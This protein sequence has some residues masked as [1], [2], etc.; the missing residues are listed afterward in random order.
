VNV[1]GDLPYPCHVCGKKFN[2]SWNRN[3]HMRVH[4]GINPHRCKLCCKNFRSSIR[5]REHLTV[6]HALS[7][8]EITE[9]MKIAAIEDMA[10]EMHG[11]QGL[12]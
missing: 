9:R 6:I 12:T 4:S 2:Q 1:I 8:S 5:L 3:V 7:E 10:N 11:R